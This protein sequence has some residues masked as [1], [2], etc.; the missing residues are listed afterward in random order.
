MGDPEFLATL[1]MEGLPSSWK[2]PSG[3]D[4]SSSINRLMPQDLAVGLAASVAFLNAVGQIGSY[5]CYRVQ[6]LHF[7]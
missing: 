2:E 3:I 4:P 6:S 7:A 1:A 5:C